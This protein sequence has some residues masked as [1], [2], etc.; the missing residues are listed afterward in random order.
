M[1]KKEYSLS[2]PDHPVSFQI[3]NSKIMY[4]KIITTISFFTILFLLYKGLKDGKKPNPKEDLT[5]LG[6]WI[7]A[8]LVN[9]VNAKS[10]KSIISEYR[11]RDDIN[12]AWLTNIEYK[13]EEKF[14]EFLV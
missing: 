4:I 7:D 11:D 3:L 13:F 1:R 6:V 12:Q 9:A 2:I 10:L 14:K 8:S 5:K